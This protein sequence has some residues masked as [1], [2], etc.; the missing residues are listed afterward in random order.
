MVDIPETAN[1]E[2]VSRIEQNDA[3]IGGN[4]T[5]PPNLQ[6][7]QL[8]NRDRWLYDAL[9]VLG[10]SPLSTV[11]EIRE[12]LAGDATQATT[13]SATLELGAA[14]VAQGR[15]TLATGDPTP[16]TEQTA[17]NTLYYT[18]FN[19][20][21]IAIYNTAASRWEVKVFSELTFD[22]SGLLANTN[23]DI[24]LYS[25]GGTLTLDAV[26]WSNSGAGTSARDKA[27]SRKNG[28]WVKTEDNR[29][30]LGTIRTTSTVGECED[31]SVKRFV[32]NAQNQVSKNFFKSL[33]NWTCDSSSF[34]FLQADNSNVFSVVTGLPATIDV[35]NTIG[36]IQTNS[37]ENYY[38]EYHVNTLG[39][40]YSNSPYYSPANGSGG[41]NVFF[42]GNF[43]TIFF[44]MEGFNILIPAE[45]RGGTFAIELQTGYMAG[46]I[47]M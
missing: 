40:R 30:Y 8:A 19:G 42:F 35:T 14:S 7:K 34:Q 5:T 27:L 18:P 6:N 21:R 43:Q 23:Y 20:D 22:I 32:F 37:S 28:I 17:A 44:D 12:S 47:T 45:S 36:R 9:A 11:N 2:P 4:I 1:F 41:Q 26:A 15:L 29:R 39:D 24:F 46:K 25:N 31:S 38:F 33:G 13:E 10:L 3:A 16:S